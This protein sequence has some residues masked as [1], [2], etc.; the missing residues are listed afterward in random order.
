MV[1]GNV[2]RYP[3]RLLCAPDGVC[4]TI[5]LEYCFEIRYCHEQQNA[6]YTVAGYIDVF[7]CVVRETSGLCA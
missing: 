2:R 7:V 6:T 1:Y 4:S 5:A 3:V